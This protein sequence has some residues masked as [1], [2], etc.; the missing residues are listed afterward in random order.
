MHGHTLMLPSIAGGEDKTSPFKNRV[1]KNAQH[2]RKWAKRTPDGLYSASMIAIS[3]N[4]PWR[5][6]IY[7][8]G[9]ASNIFPMIATDDEPLCGT[10]RGDRSRRCSRGFLVLSPTQIYWRTQGEADPD[11]AV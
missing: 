9:S 3:R 4:T 2:V 5:S 7:R 1:R 11:P 10:E 8:G 6:N